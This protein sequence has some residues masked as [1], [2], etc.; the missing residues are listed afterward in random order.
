[1]RSAPSSLS[2]KAATAFAII[3]SM[4]AFL[5]LYKSHLC[6]EGV[7]PLPEAHAAPEAP[8]L[9]IEAPM[10]EPDM[11]QVFTEQTVILKALS[12][13]VDSVNQSLAEI[14]VI[15]KDEHSR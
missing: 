8:A 14:T 6:P 11:R 12:E 3:L 2:G 13:D 9:D 7:Q 15:L 10:S 4:V 1:M 5:S